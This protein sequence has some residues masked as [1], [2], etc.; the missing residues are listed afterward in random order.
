MAVILDGKT[1][2]AKIRSDLRQRLNQQVGNG[3]EIPS[4]TAVQVGDDLPSTVYIR[5]KRRACEE[6]GFNFNHLK[7]PEATTMEQLREALEELNNDRSVHSFLVQ[8]PLPD[9]LIE[10]EV[11]KL[12]SP[13]KDV[14]CFHPEN[15]GLIYIGQPR[16]LPC[17]A[18]AVIEMLLY[19]GCDPAGKKVAIIGRSVIVGRPLALMMGLKGRGGNATV[20][21]CHSRTENLPEITR[22][23][24]IVIPAV[25]VSE[26]I[27]GDWVKE[28]VV[29]VDVGINRVPDSTRKAGYRL[30]GDAAFDEIEPK[31]AAIAPVPGGVGPMTVAIL[32]RNIMVAAGLDPG[33]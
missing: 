9:H 13:Q 10:I 31:A 32:C 11:Q 24:D 4:F 8:S 23:A 7:L 28:G 6:M 21:L 5:A 33:F 15:V 29:V 25:G 12:V 3:A 14:D 16:F 27:K 18:A 22:Q 19:Y 20:T 1:L 17:T 30:V 26:L 2:S